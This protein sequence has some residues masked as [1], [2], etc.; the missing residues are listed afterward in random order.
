M[1][2][3]DVHKFKQEQITL[4]EENLRTIKDVDVLLEN[5]LS[6]ARKI[7]NADAGSIYEYD[8]KENLLR[9]RYSQNDTLQSKL[10]K[11]EKLP[12]VSYT[13]LPSSQS[14][15]G[16]CVLSKKIINIP[17]VYNLEP[18]ITNS[19]G[20]VISCPFEFNKESDIKTGYHTKSMLTIPLIMTN[21][22]VLGVLQIINARDDFGNPVPFDKD[23]EFFITQFAN[24]VGSI[25]EYAY[26]TR[27]NI[28]RL[29]RMAGFRDP[30]E[31]GAHVERVS[32]FA[33][34]IYDRYAAN[35]NIPEKVRNKF[36]DNLRLAARCHD[37]GKVAVPDEILKK[38]G[39]L[40]E[41]ERDIMKGHTCVGAQIFTPIEN[42]TDQ[43]IRDV[44]LH[45]HDRWDGGDKGYPGNYN[46]MDYIPETKMPHCIE[47]E[48]KGED[49]PLA[50]RIVSLADVYDALR[51]KRC[52][53]REWTEK[54]TFQEIADQSGQQFDPE[55]VK[56]FF[57]IKDRLE[58]INRSIDNL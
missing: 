17:D 44:C 35:K 5:I 14:I 23:S 29:V 24:K 6:G 13:L 42:E 2:E 39:I 31:T 15:A 38:E 27:L 49:I 57:Q 1:E 25:Y 26:L 34:E 22:K 12:Y 56:A 46:Y 54:D 51:H 40:D 8:S 30:R 41:D 4:I 7:V 45:H 3:F 18:N 21:G 9:I 37:V 47:Q 10:G 16:Y 58:D 32:S 52:Y 43:M 48:L 33:L 20:E 53:K 28:D 55:L 36:R 11:G 19:N 50:A